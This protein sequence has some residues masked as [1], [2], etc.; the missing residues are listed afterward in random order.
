MPLA[1]LCAS[2]GRGDHPEPARSTTDDR[3]FA[4]V[5]AADSLGHDNSHHKDKD[6][7]GPESNGAEVDADEG[8]GGD[9]PA[10][11]R[12]KWGI[13]GT[14]PANLVHGRRW[15]GGS[16]S[17]ATTGPT[18][19][20]GASATGASGSVATAGAAAAAAVPPHHPAGATRER[21]VL[22]TTNAEEC[23]A[24]VDEINELVRRAGVQRGGGGSSARGRDLFDEWVRSAVGRDAHAVDL[25][26]DDEAAEGAP[27]GRGTAVADTPVALLAG[28]E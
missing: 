13:G 14:L 24:L 8:G 6:G 2:K 4:L 22:E 17:A 27:E 9:S 26:A 3:C 7:G 28:G 20:L 16:G 18:G 5:Q 21:M 10:P 23:T 25:G 1:G 19:R 11:G 15:R 12:R